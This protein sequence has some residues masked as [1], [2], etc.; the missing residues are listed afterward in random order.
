MRKALIISSFTAKFLNIYN[1]K[2][3]QTIS[4]CLAGSVAS[5]RHANDPHDCESRHYEKSSDRRD[6]QRSSR[7]VSSHPGYQGNG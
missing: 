4:F 1:S 7:V 6:A 5:R 2:F 3:I